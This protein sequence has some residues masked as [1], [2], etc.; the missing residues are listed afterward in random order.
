[1]EKNKILFL[2]LTTIIGVH[3]VSAQTFEESRTIYPVVKNDGA[4]VITGFTQFDQKTDEQILAN[5]MKWAI[6]E[7][8][9]EKRDA[10]FDISVNKKDFSLNMAFNQVLDGKTKYQ[11]SCKANVRVA[12]G[13]LVYMLYDIQYKTSSL[14]QFSS[15]YSLDKLTPEKKPKHKE[16][17]QAFQELAS[18]KLNQMFDAVVGNQCTPITHWSDINIQRPVKGMNED[19][20]LLAFGKPNNNYEDSNGRVQWSYGLNFILI[21][22]EKKLETIIR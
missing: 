9:I 14:L 4:F 1:M 5:A 22:K 10:L 20:C 18:K 12:E 11:F 7:Y 15:A 21:F 8:C 13:K 2:L 19:E 16:I 6:D 3:S 17:V